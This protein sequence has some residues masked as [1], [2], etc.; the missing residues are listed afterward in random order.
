MASLFFMTENG[1]KEYGNRNKEI[2]TF[3]VFDFLSSKFKIMIEKFEDLNVWQESVQLSIKLY[4]LLNNCKDFSLRDQIQRS[5]DSIASN[6]AE[7]FERTNKEFIHFLLISKSFC[8]ELRTQLFIAKE[9][10]LIAIEES[11]ILIETTRKISAML[12]NLN[13]TRK[14]NFH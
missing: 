6:I 13:K 4:S 1:E 11:E 2:Y 14:S 3:S 8:S 12:S 9:I 5:S 10:K 7:G